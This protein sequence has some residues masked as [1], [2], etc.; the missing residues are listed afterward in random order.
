V[1]PLKK[2]AQNMLL[3][4]LPGPEKKGDFYVL[5]SIGDVVSMSIDVNA[6]N[7]QQDNGSLNRG[8]TSYRHA[9]A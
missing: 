3:P 4:T 6:E 9:H 2:T 7:A 8:R 1:G 5:S